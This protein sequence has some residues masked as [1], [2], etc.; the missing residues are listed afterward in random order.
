MYVEASLRLENETASLISPVYGAEYSQN[1]CLKM[2]VYLHGAD[3][4]SLVVGQFPER[5]PGARL[6]LG[7]LSGGMDR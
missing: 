1:S 3:M 4:G 7:E 6:V 2:A 5:E